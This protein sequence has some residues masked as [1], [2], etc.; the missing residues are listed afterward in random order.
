[1][2]VP[3]HLTTLEF[4][5]MVA[6]LL[7]EDGVYAVNIVDKM[8][9][10]RFLRSVVATLGETFPH[11]YVMRDDDF[12]RSDDRYTFVVAASREPLTPSR[13]DEANLARGVEPTVTRFMPGSQMTRWLDGPKTILTDD[14]VP[15]DGML[16]P[17]YLESR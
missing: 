5:E 15:V 13:I 4:N 17:L 3:Y 11:V 7:S 16:A 8:H 6:A 1:M 10:G 9:G 12:W 2:S 14:F